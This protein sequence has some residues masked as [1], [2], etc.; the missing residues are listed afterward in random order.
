MARG[1]LRGA[2]CEGRRH[3]NNNY[4]AHRPYSGSITTSSF[5]SAPSPK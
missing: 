2:A 3:C 1:S 5:V 4:A